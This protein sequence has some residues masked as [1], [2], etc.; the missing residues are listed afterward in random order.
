MVA[1]RL[2]CLVPLLAA[3]LLPA[4]FLRSI[5]AEPRRTTRASWLGRS[6][7]QNVTIE[8]GQPVW[9]AEYEGLA[10]AMS[11]G[12]MLLGK[13]AP[14]ELRNDVELS[15][16]D[17][18]VP[19]GRYYVGARRD[20]EQRWELAL[21]VAAKVDASGHATTTML[22]TDPDLRVP[23]VFTREKEPVAAFE[24]TL[25]ERKGAPTGLVL[26]IAWGPYR[27]RAE[28]TAAFDV[29]Q[30]EGAPQFALTAAG[31]GVRT[32]SGLVYEVLRAGS[33]AKPGP[34]DT[35]RAHYA[36]WLQDGT[37]FCSSHVLG[38]PEPLRMDWVVKGFAEGLQAMQV[39]GV[40][41]FTIPAE[42][43]FGARGNGRVPPDATLV[44]VVT[45]VGIDAR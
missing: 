30:P 45:L 9:R 39:G 20:A 22:S 12:P 21:F 43:A 1:R 13:G 44:Y 3:S 29:R 11:A 34:T 42:L 32:V 37:M 8:H 10:E 15:L 19:A 14:T 23:M 41:R 25:G 6:G 17:R 28:L 40:Y 33:G 26:S 24:I 16:G 38:E 36:G 7:E 35:V 5:G 4:Q 31:K 2:V 27:L 18:K